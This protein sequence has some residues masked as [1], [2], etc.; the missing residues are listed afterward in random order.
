MPPPSPDPAF[1]ATWIRSFAAS[2]AAT[3]AE[4]SALDQ[5]VG[6]GD[7]GANLVAGLQATLRLLGDAGGPGGGAAAP[8]ARLAPAAREHS[9]EPDL[10]P[11]T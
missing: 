5:Q 1:T 6:D 2:A 8:L 7:F 9:D 11:R 3:E 4:L 10:E